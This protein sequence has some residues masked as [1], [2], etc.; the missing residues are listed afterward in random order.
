MKGTWVINSSDIAHGVETDKWIHT[1]QFILQAS[2]Y[3][4]RFCIYMLKGMN[5]HS[6]SFTMKD[7]L[8]QLPN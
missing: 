1:L 2:Q 8:R 5:G 4:S 3:N 6:Y 7:I